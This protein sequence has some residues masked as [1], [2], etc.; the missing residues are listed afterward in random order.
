MDALD[1]IILL[2]NIYTASSTIQT[3]VASANAEASGYL[4][5]Y[6]ENVVFDDANGE[7]ID[8]LYSDIYERAEQKILAIIAESKRRRYSATGKRQTHL[9]RVA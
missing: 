3:I 2:K 6:P 5:R 7:I 1:R 4:C 8:P 9:R